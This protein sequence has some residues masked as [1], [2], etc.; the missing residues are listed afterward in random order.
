MNTY[1]ILIVDDEPDNFD[2]IQSLL[3]G[4]SHN[5]HYAISG[6][7]AIASLDKFDP[8][9]DLARCDDARSQWHGSMQT[10]QGNV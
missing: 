7:N 1:S 2:V 5:L 10:D 8:D 6:E 3:P 4:E 9:V